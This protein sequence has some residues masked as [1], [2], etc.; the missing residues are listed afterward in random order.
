MG[1][2]YSAAQIDEVT[3]DTVKKF[4]SKEFQALQDAIDETSYAW[5]DVAKAGQFDSIESDCGKEISKT[6]ENLR[7]A[8]EKKTRLQLFIGYHDCENDGDRYDDVDGTY[9]NVSGMYQLT[10][11]GKKMKKYVERKYFV[12]LG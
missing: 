6:F 10:P 1:M 3:V 7:K 4:C 9:W 5:E 2:G 12:Q 8:F 11:A